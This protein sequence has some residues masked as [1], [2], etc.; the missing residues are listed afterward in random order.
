MSKHRGFLN[1]KFSWSDDE[2]VYIAM[3]PC[4][5]NLM[6]LYLAPTKKVEPQFL[7]CL[8][9]DMAAALDFMHQNNVVHLDISPSNILVTKDRS[10]V[11]WNFGKARLLN[12]DREILEVE[13]GD[14]RYLAPELRREVNWEEVLTG[15]VDLRKADIYSLGLVLIDMLVPRNLQSGLEGLSGRE[16]KGAL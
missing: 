15:V 10:F 4:L 12:E 1:Y 11:L 3:E 13:E 5:G 2:L 16:A 9:K 8:I 6:D 7:G 14:F